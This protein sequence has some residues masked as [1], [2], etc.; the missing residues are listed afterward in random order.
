MKNDILEL[1]YSLY[2]K[3]TLQKIHI[4]KV[5]DLKEYDCLTLAKALPQDCNKALIIKK[6][7]DLGYLPS[8]ENAIS[9]YD[10]PMS[11]KMRNIFSRNGIVCLA[12]LSAYP[13]EEILQFHRVGEYSMSEIDTLCE[14]YGI[15]IRSLSP[16][17]EAF[18]EFQFHKKIYPLFFRGNIFSVDDIRNKSAHDLYNICEQ[19]YCLTMKTYYALRKNGVTLCGWNDQ[20]LFEILPQYKSVRLF[21]QY[22]I[23]AVS[24]LS[25]RSG[26]QLKI[27]SD[28]VPELSSLI[29]KLLADTHM[30]KVVD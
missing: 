27:I 1:Q 8:A 4:T 11:R 25:D 9:I 24:Q 5:S 6:L 20:Y 3:K 23:I 18:S 15:Q 7:N 10:I 2:I 22:G 13:R 28:S 29:Q 14:K 30:D 16:I 17:K 19:D 12:Q 26:Q 21:K